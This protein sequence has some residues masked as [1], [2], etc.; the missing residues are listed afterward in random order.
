MQASER[1]TAK[2]K[3]AIRSLE[4]FPRIGRP[5]ARSGMRERFVAFG[6]GAY[7]IRY[8]HSLRR[9]SIVILRIWHSREARR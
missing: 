4:E 2:L 1:A 9:D 8:Y 6:K 5:L 7:I 3:E